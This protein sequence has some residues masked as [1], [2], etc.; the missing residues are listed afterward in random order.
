[1]LYIKYGDIMEMIIINGDKED[2]I[3][4]LD[5]HT[6]TSYRF[7]PD[8]TVE[9][10][11]EKIYD[12]F[13]FLT[14]K[15]QHTLRLPNEGNYDV[16]LNLETNFKHYYQNGKQDFAMFFSNN[17]QIAIAVDLLSKINFLQQLKIP[18]IFE[19]KSGGVLKGE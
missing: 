13:D 12:Y 4:Y 1:M 5:K 18:K 14:P 7:L 8:N 6:L 9:N 2:I 16:L 10:I 15:S 3:A 17:G 11:G 19:I